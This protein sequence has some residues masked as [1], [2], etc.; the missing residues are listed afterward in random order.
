MWRSA[1]KIRDVSVARTGSS[2]HRDALG[3]GETGGRKKGKGG[4]REEKR[5]EREGGERGEEERRGG[6]ERERREGR[7]NGEGREG[8]RGNGERKWGEERRGER[9][10]KWDQVQQR[11]N[12]QSEPAS[13]PWHITCC[14]ARHLSPLS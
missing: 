5:E 10:W 8:G 1:G 7:G 4:G 2:A 12:T 11:Y 14:Y 6:E 13:H 3:I 9:K